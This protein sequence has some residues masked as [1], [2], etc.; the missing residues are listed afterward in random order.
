MTETPLIRAFGGEA[1]SIFQ[2]VLRFADDADAERY[3]AGWAT[4]EGLVDDWDDRGFVWTIDDSSADGS[5][6][7]H[8]VG[9]GPL[10]GP[11]T[12]EGFEPAVPCAS[13]ALCWQA[14]VGDDEY[15]S[16]VVAARRGRHVTGLGARG[17]VDGDRAMTASV[18]RLDPDS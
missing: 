2:V 10:W 9:C 12:E 5:Y 11:L 1:D 13:V 4:Y 18:G 15:P 7:T 14:S 16:I 8:S 17:S 3:L 6:R